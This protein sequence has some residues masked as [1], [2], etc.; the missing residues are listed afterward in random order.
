[1]DYSV[2]VTQKGTYTYPIHKHKD[3][4][5][6]LYFDGTGEMRTEIG[7]FP[8]CRGT[9]IIMP[10]GM[11][12]GSSSE[13]TFCNLSI[14]GDSPLFPEIKKPSILNSNDDIMAIGETIAKNRFRDNGYIN[15]LIDT[16]ILMILDA[17]NV[18]T[19]LEE[20]IETI[21]NKIHHSFLNDDFIVERELEQSGYA[22][23]YIRSAF[24]QKTGKRPIEYMNDCRIRNAC[25][26]FK[27]YGRSLSVI[28]VAGK[29]GFKDAVY[30]SKQFKKV[31]GVSPSEYLKSITE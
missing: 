12:H 19:K 22:E 14:S 17:M 6:M 23:D 5:I 9:I 24:K 30:F 16:Y 26:L 8:F 28:E 4:E 21:Q 10:K 3:V 7:I 15:S 27:I 1:M 13:H 31:T 2:N 29:C 18:K 25:R 11:L 20:S